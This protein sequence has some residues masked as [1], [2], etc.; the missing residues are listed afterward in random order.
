MLVVVV[1]WLLIKARQQ[2]VLNTLISMQS[3][4]AQLLGLTKSW[5]AELKTN[6]RTTYADNAIAN[7]LGFYITT[8]RQHIPDIRIW[9]KDNALFPRYFWLCISQNRFLTMVYLA[10][11]LELLDK[12]EDH[13]QHLMYGTYDYY[14]A[15][16]LR[17]QVNDTIKNN[18]GFKLA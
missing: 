14:C 4:V 12:I 6:K 2:A 7:I 17:K 10:A 8:I 16:D 13:F 15:Q 5:E 1:G 18:R 9:Q 3:L 11:L